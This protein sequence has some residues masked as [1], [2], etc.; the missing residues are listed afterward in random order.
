[1]YD[2]Q[3]FQVP[4]P[5]LDEYIFTCF[6]RMYRRFE[7]D[8]GQL[9]PQQLCE[10]RYEDL[11]RDPIGQMRNVYQQFE[12]DGFARVQ[13]QLA[14]YFEEKQEYKTNQHRLDQA[15]RQQVEDRW[16]PFMRATAMAMRHSKGPL[17]RSR[18]LELRHG[19]AGYLAAAPG[20]GFPLS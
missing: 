1:M 11:V 4:P 19:N 18:P 13:P 10:V 3:A 5:H 15:V 9:S 20:N 2:S 16:G 8:R 14:A 7:E 17:T 12:L 6:E